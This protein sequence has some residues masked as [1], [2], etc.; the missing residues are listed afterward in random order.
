MG[1]LGAGARAKLQPLFGVQATPCPPLTRAQRV[2]GWSRLGAG[3][4]SSGVVCGRMGYCELVRP[5]EPAAVQRIERTYQ[6]QRCVE[7]E[8]PA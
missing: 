2:E 1:D 8:V 5:F 7:A 4:T 6:Q 3:S